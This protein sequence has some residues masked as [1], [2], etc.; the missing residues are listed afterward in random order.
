MSQAQERF[1][2][3]VE[4]FT[5]TS[6]RHASESQ[7]A[8]KAFSAAG[9]IARHNPAAAH[10]DR[11]RTTCAQSERGAQLSCART[12]DSD[13]PHCGLEIVSKIV[14]GHWIWHLMLQSYD[15]MLKAV[16]VWPLTAIVGFPFELVAA[17]G[18]QQIPMLRE[19]HPFVPLGGVGN[20]SV[21]TAL[22]GFGLLFL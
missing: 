21:E 2:V 10:R 4:L 20:I 11:M 1:P 22:H 5:H 8:I 19:S 18:V 12:L 14:V 7:E 16:L 9:R 17:V 3:V 15:G 13:D 6:C